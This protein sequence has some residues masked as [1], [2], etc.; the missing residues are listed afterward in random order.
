MGFKL[1]TN[2]LGL[3][4]T[5]VEDSEGTGSWR[6]AKKALRNWYL[7]QAHALRTVDQKSYFRVDA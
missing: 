5:I 6:D 7:E 1:E 4:P 3:P 2:E